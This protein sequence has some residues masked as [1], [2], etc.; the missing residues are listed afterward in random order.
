MPTFCVIPSPLAPVRID[1]E[2]GAIVA[3]NFVDETFCPPSTPLLTEAARQLDAYFAGALTAFD[4]PIRMT[5]T[6]FRVKCWEALCTI[7]FGETL[8]YGEQARRVGNPKATR[9]VGGANHCNPI[10]IV[11]PCHRVIGANGTLTGY[12]GGLDKKA[13]LLAH[14]QRVLRQLGQERAGNN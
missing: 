9:A 2:D 3:I 4:L 1:A 13:W 14:E 11:V 7:P 12:G 10:N 6:A 8:S 5:G